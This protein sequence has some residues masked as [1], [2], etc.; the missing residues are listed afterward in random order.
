[1]LANIFVMG[2]SNVIAAYNE[3]MKIIGN[4]YNTLPSAHTSTVCLASVAHIWKATPI[5]HR[6]N[7]GLVTGPGYK[8]SANY[9]VNIFKAFRSRPWFPT[10]W[11]FEA[12]LRP[13]I[14]GRALN[15][16][17]PP[18]PTHPPF[19]L[20]QRCQNTFAVRGTPLWSRFCSFIVSAPSPALLM[21]LLEERWSC[22]FLLNL[23][24]GSL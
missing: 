19:L 9:P 7:L 18:P 12:S 17:P 21:A 23:V 11:F 16:K 4:G 2:Y 6:L 14:R 24:P 8:A 22:I 15:V 20:K 3:G 5:F 10:D 13:W 1:M